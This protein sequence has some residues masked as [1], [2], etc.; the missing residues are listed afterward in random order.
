MW[1]WSTEPTPFRL[2]CSA[3][4]P[5][6]FFRPGHATCPDIARYH[7]KR[8][9]VGEGFTP[10]AVMPSRVTEQVGSP[11]C[12]ACSDEMRLTMIIP[13]FGSPHGLKGLHLPQMRT[14]GE[15]PHDSAP[16]GGLGS[17]NGS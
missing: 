2:I 4:H 17:A 8:P 13:P 12:L 3:P 7:S 9:F 6:S 5:S 11:H 15:L 14:L 10:E 1:A 16:Q